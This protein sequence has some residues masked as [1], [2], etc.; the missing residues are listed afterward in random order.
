MAAFTNPPL[1]KPEFESQLG[2]LIFVLLA[3]DNYVS[4]RRKTVHPEVKW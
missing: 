2:N 1:T 4:G 3:L